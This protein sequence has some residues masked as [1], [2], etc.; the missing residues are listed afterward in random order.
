MRTDIT[1][2]APP[3]WESINRRAVADGVRDI[4]DDPGDTA[5]SVEGK[6]A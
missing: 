3:G 5:G 1:R 6:G 2:A 4:K